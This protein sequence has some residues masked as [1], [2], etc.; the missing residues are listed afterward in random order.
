MGA[1]Q[2]CFELLKNQAE[3][4]QTIW[5]KPRL[6][7]ASAINKCCLLYYARFASIVYSIAYRVRDLQGR[8]W[9]RTILQG[10]KA[11]LRT[12]RSRHHR[13]CRLLALSNQRRTNV[14][15]WR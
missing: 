2:R 11:G 4:G 12:Q 10:G 8:D 7:I 9:G 15:C 14:G 5:L 3:H 1:L 6:G 13:S